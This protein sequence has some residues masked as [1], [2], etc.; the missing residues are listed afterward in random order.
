[1]KYTHLL[2]SETYPKLWS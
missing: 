1:M 2:A